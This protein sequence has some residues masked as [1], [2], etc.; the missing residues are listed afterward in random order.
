MAKP[1]EFS[2]SILM[3]TS[4]QHIDTVKLDIA[5]EYDDHMSAELQSN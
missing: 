3:V 2:L 5:K 1:A 4:S